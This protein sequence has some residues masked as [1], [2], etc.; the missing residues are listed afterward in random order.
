MLYVPN[1]QKQKVHKQQ[2]KKALT[3]ENIHKFYTKK[4]CIKATLF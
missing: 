1:P 3:K 4:N 2:K